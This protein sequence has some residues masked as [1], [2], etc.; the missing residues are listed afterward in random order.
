MVLIRENKKNGE[1]TLVGG[2]QKQMDRGCG[3][4]RNNWSVWAR[5]R[6]SH[7]RV[8]EQ[9]GRYSFL[10]AARSHACENMVPFSRLQAQWET[11]EG[12]QAAGHILL[13]WIS[14]ASSIKQSKSVLLC[15]F[16]PYSVYF[17]V[18]HLVLIEKNEEESDRRA[19]DTKGGNWCC[20]CCWSLHCSDNENR[21]GGWHVG[22]ML[23]GRE[24][25][26]PSVFLCVRYNHVRTTRSG[27]AMSEESL[28]PLRPS[29]EEC[30][31]W[32]NWQN[33]RAQT[34]S[35]PGVLRR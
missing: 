2:L 12:G 17:S 34:L 25:V 29:G 15:F 19:R 6:E 16:K 11:E 4:K 8:Y 33:T 9:T 18:A 23:L 31:L 21:I 10:Q 13:F 30:W 1:R 22:I 3:E 7:K 35:L 20:C 5:G 28:P 14:R 27:R 26:S 32:G 24:L